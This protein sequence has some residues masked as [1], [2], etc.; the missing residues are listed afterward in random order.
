MAQV[1]QA[2]R[3]REA[4]AHFF[5]FKYAQGVLFQAAFAYCVADLVGVFVAHM[6]AFHKSRE[7]VF[8]NVFKQLFA[9]TKAN[10][11][12]QGGLSLNDIDQARNLHD[13][14]VDTQ[15]LFDARQKLEKIQLTSLTELIKTL[16][17]SDSDGQ[18][19]REFG[20]IFPMLRGKG[21]LSGYAVKEDGS[22]VTV[23]HFMPRQWH[24][25]GDLRNQPQFTAT[26]DEREQERKKK[27]L[28][29]I[30]KL[31]RTDKEE[32]LFEAMASSLDR[33]RGDSRKKSNKKS[34]KKKNK[35]KNKGDRNRYL[36]Y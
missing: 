13:S 4:D 1:V 28:E 7:T 22:I 31:A 15:R 23:R 9:V 17:Q 30:E 21:L 35:K 16:L 5:R 12:D 6:L 14:L 32:D 34:N 26:G 29:R 25:V 27:A 18:V 10:T 19:A 36:Y 11:S 20:S 3:Q 2:V 8:K 24:P 33:A